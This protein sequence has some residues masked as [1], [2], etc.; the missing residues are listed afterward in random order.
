MTRNYPL[1]LLI[2]LLA[3]MPASAGLCA[4]E[5]FQ[6]P[7]KGQAAV[8]MRQVSF[9]DYFMDEQAYAQTAEAKE[10]GRE[11]APTLFE[12]VPLGW[13]PDTIRSLYNSVLA[14]P[15]KAPD[16]VAY[17][18]EQGGTFGAVGSIL[19]VFFVAVLLYSVIWQKR[20]VLKIEKELQ[21]LWD[22]V[23]ATSHPHFLSF[24][25]I[26]V[27]PVLPVLLLCTSLLIQGFIHYEVP[28]LALVTKLLGLWAAGVLV[29]KILREALTDGLLPFCPLYGRSLFRTLRV[30][31]VYTMTGMAI[32]WGAE[33]IQLPDDAQ[34]FLRFAVSLTA[35]FVASSVFRKKEALLSLL[36]RLSYR[37]YQ[38]FTGFLNRA[39]FPL[40]LLTVVTGVLWCLGY[41]RLSEAAL[42]KTWGVGGAYVAIMLT[43]RFLYKRLLKWSE[44]KEHLRDE[45]AKTFFRSART[46]LQYGT[47]AI[48]TLIILHLL[49]LLK[50]LHDVLSL[51]VYTLG[52]APLSLWIFFEAGF[53][54]LAFVYVSHLLQAYLDYKIYP[55]IG[56]DT[57]LAYALNTFLKYSLFAVGFFS[58]LRAIGLDL[59][60]LM[61]FAGG[62]GI[63]TGIG[64]QHIA[65]NIISGFIIVFGRKLRKGDWIK[66]GDK[67]GMVTHIYLQATKIWTR[68]NIEY[69]VPNTDL[70]T[71]PVINYTLTSPVVRIYVPVGVSYDAD[72]S[73][74]SQILMKA[75]EK[76][77]MVTQFRKPEVRIAGFGESSLNFELLIWI[78]ISK[79]AEKDIKS[80]LYF[81][82]IEALSEAGIEIPYPQREIHIRSGPLPL[83]YSR[84]EDQKDGRDAV[85]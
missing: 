83:D 36:P 48:S 61:V 8:I 41:R 78:D 20:V 76:H 67:L 52:G 77:Q 79:V 2:L 11:A 66:V 85:S 15:A 40:A 42:I 46:F 35:V 59:R 6:P 43:Y 73:E 38:I 3:V 58:A 13:T 84:E 33:A 44:I 55:S 9:T 80:R 75:A 82:M 31:V 30:V 47:A 45:A 34:A 19:L 29:L 81:T 12:S 21:P 62:V 63:G 68:D 4:P 56:V 74:V 50:P 17:V 37:I 64:L 65:A 7:E 32:V 51:P 5:R 72:P 25:R 60:V 16:L 1:L 23:P 22:R 18:R 27:A 70:M 57:G 54:L 28:W 49:G 24:I 53:I 71:K 69:I 10:G 26:I 14:L 39:Y